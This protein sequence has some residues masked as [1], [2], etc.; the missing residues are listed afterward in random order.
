M[1]TN[2]SS[3]EKI[4]IK[5]VNLAKDIIKLSATLKFSKADLTNIEGC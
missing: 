5:L 4:K 3:E 1:I 2:S